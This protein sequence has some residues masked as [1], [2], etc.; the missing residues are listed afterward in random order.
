MLQGIL[1]VDMSVGGVQGQAGGSR[2]SFLPR[3]VLL[4]VHDYHVARVVPSCARDGVLLHVCCS[5]CSVAAV[6][7]T[8][9]SHL[10]PGAGQH[11]RHV[12]WHYELRL[13][14]EGMVRMRSGSSWRRGPQNESETRHRSRTKVQTSLETGSGDEPPESVF[15]AAS[16]DVW[17]MRVSLQ[18]KQVAEVRHCQAKF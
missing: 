18:R 5:F 11:E 12:I 3:V 2:P 14:G 9:A 10:L 15:T 6:V 16:V 7:M 4:A 13:G 1:Q 17:R 8:S